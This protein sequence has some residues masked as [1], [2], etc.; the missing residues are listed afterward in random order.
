MLSSSHGRSRV[1]GGH[2]KD[3]YKEVEQ[4]GPEW[5]C[6]PLEGGLTSTIRERQDNG[7]FTS[8]T[9]IS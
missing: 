5:S 2:G 4:L 9:S 3:C 7:S 8:E 1:G 6:G